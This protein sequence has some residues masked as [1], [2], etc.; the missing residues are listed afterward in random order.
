M[1][2]ADR[3]RGYDFAVSVIREAEYATVAFSGQAYAVPLSPVFL[4]DK[5]YFH[6]AKE[7]EKL[8]RIK[9]DPHVCIT[10][11]SKA[12]PKPGRFGLDF[13]SAVFFA[14]AEIV[15]DPEEK[16]AALYEMAKVHAPTTP[17]RMDKYIKGFIDRAVVLRMN[18][19][20]ATGKECIKK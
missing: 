12:D 10:A 7:G 13:R 17:D 18:I 3:E 8:E 20:S 2:R 6:C 11:V 5:I 19:L 15:E 9:Q 14:E 4:N 1:R 16:Y